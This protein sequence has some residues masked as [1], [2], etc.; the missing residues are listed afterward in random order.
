M[1]ETRGSEYFRIDGGRYHEIDFGHWLVNGH[2]R[3]TTLLTKFVRRSLGSLF[4]AILVATMGC[5]STG[6]PVDSEARNKM[7]SLLMPN[8][9]EIVEP[10]TR[11]RSFDE[12][13]EADGVEL[14][15]QAVNALD[16]PGLMIVGS[17]RVELFEFVPASGNRRGQRLE[18]WDVAISTVQAQRTY[19]NSITQ[20]YEF[21]LA[22]DAGRIPPND[23]FVLLVTYNSPLGEHL[24]DE[25]VITHRSAIGPL[26]GVRS[27]P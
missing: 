12:D 17:V 21:R 10:F 7:L 24:T 22:V 4:G 3:N 5:A 15:L 1:H 14:L 13:A 27:A 2:W 16:N 6:D 19:W 11:V 26:G 23:K 9:V 20:M 8:R 18:Y 25:C